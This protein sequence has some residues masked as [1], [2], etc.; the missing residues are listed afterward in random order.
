MF[1]RDPEI[2]HAHGAMYFMA[3]L[4]KSYWQDVICCL[5]TFVEGKLFGQR[6]EIHL[7]VFDAV[8]LFHMLG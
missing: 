2:I 1:V 3:W 5:Q 6:R 7:H 4:T 8:R